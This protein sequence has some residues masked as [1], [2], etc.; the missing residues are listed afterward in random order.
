MP[1]LSPSVRKGIR[2]TSPIF[3]TFFI[4]SIEHV[5]LERVLSPAFRN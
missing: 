5:M 1:D 4:A 3:S 2:V